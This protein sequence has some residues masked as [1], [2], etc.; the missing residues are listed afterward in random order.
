V[1]RAIS[2][3]DVWRAA[4][5]SRIRYVRADTNHGAAWNFCRV[6]E[7]SRGR[8]FKWAASD[9]ICAPTFV[10]KA[11]AVLESDPTVVC[12]HARAVK[13]DQHGELR[14]DQVGHIRTHN[15][16]TTLLVLPE[17]FQRSYGFAP[18]D[19]VVKHPG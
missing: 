8:Y 3:S 19:I 5:D 11:I 16:A 17:R 15:T 4:A 12:C 13:I 2:S 18:S 14:N 1:A 10:E 6:V 7:L 9:D